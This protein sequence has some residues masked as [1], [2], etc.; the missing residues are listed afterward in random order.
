M[1]KTQ[2]IISR[3]RLALY[4]QLLGPNS[5]A[6][7]ALANYDAIKAIKANKGKAKIEQELTGFMVWNGSMGKRFG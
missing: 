6:A 7:E 2:N 1:A 5:H 4:A 3:R